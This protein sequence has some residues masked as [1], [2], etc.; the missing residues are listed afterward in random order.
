MFV[1][2]VNCPAFQVTA[3]GEFEYHTFRHG[4][5]YNKIPPEEAHK[6]ESLESTTSQRGKKVRKEVDDA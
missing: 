5:I 1:L 2:K 3:E 6:F 4:E